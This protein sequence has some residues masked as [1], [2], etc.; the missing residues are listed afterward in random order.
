MII[1]TLCFLLK[2]NTN[3]IARLIK[4]K[5]YCFWLSIGVMMISTAIGANTNS[6]K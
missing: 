2:P 6:S 1:D 5:I 3:I 4:P